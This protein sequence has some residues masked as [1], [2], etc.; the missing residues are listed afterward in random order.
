MLGAAVSAS[1]AAYYGF[2]VL[3]RRAVNVY[4]VTLVWLPSALL[5]AMLGQACDW[6]L[7]ITWPSYQARVLLSIGWM[8]AGLMFRRLTDRLAEAVSPG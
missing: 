2:A 1:L 4:S 3:S 5:L 8:A 6:L 7:G